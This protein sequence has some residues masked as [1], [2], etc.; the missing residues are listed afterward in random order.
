MSIRLKSNHSVLELTGLAGWW[1]SNVD[2]QW[3]LPLY[4]LHRSL[5]NPVPHGRH[6]L[7]WSGFG[8][9]MGCQEGLSKTFAIFSKQQY[10][11]SVIVFDSFALLE[12][13]WSFFRHPWPCLSATALLFKS[14]GNQVREASN[15][16]KA[17][18][19]SVWKPWDPAV[20]PCSS[21]QIHWEV[22]IWTVKFTTKHCLSLWAVVH[23]CIWP[24]ETKSIRYTG[25]MWPKACQAQLHWAELGKIS[26]SVGWSHSPACLIFF[27][28][29][30]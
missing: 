26:V 16:S 19:K 1:E 20:S 13:G 3:N 21:F 23:S 28:V 9:G 30:L 29:S 11:E 24:L 8:W 15:L 7:F 6:N 22:H 10:S 14:L 4:P 12:L 5:M 17:W 2:G 18:V 25:C 27:C